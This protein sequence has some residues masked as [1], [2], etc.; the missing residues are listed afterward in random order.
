MILLDNIPTVWYVYKMSTANHRKKNP[1]LVKQSLIECAATVAATEGMNHISIQ[2]V[3]GM[4]GVTKGGLLHH[5]PSRRHLLD[6]L[7]D[8][9]LKD[10]EA[11][12]NSRME[13]DNGY[14]RF[15]RAYISGMLRDLTDKSKPAEA[16]L[17]M[18]LDKDLSAAWKAWMS[19][20]LEAHKETDG[21]EW[22]ETLRYASDGVWLA[23]S[24][25]SLQDFE[26][27]AQ[28]LLKATY[29]KVEI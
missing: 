26:T 18:L 16:T 14:G 5:F 13:N 29:K 22:L 3:A 20:K 1:E 8:H 7:Y 11:K 21:D 27:I 4:A 24:C 2:K 17:S 12:I 28:R 23:V 6:A 15:T 10:I 9:L 25:G 19:R